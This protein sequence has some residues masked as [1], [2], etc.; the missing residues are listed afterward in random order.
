MNETKEKSLYFLEKKFFGPYFASFYSLRFSSPIILHFKGAH[1][2]L[3][4]GFSFYSWGLLPRS[5]FTSLYNK[6]AHVHLRDGSLFLLF[7]TF[8]PNHTLLHFI[9]VKE[10][11]YTYAT[12]RYF[13]LWDFSSPIILQFIYSEGTHVHLR[14]DSSQYFSGFLFSN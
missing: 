5:Y 3:R 9:I 7:G 4:D 11:M 14:D 1:I 10:L 2:H 6:R 12:A 8:F 13:T